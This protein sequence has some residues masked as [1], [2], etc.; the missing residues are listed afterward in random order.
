LKYICEDSNVVS[1]IVE[2]IIQ[3]WAQSLPFEEKSGSKQ[4]PVELVITLYF[5]NTM[6]VNTTSEKTKELLRWS[7]EKIFCNLVIMI[8]NSIQNVKPH[9]EKNVDYNT[10]KKS[11]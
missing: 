11:N 10:F 6:F 5:L 8:S 4:F 2:F 7:F 1:G 9:V 3:L